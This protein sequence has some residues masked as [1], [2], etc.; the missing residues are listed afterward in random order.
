MGIRF[1]QTNSPRT[2]SPFPS[3]TMAPPSN[4]S[5][6]EP[7][8]GSADSNRGRS[9]R[10]HGGSSGSRR[11]GE[12]SRRTPA[13]GRRRNDVNGGAVD[14]IDSHVKGEMYDSA[15][16]YAK[17]PPEQAVRVPSDA[18]YPE[19]QYCYPSAQ[20]PA[21]EPTMYDNELRLDEEQPQAGTAQTHQ[22]TSY[23]SG[24]H[25]SQQMQSQY[26]YPQIPAQAS[27]RPRTPVHN[28]YQNAP[29]SPTTQRWSAEYCA[30]ERLRLG[31]PRFATEAEVE[32]A[33]RAYEHATHQADHFGAPQ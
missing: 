26:Q 7:H 33:R 18:Y 6:L 25:Y 17:S 29:T 13:P 11:A 23:S 28:N 9:P 10:P 20:F 3:D 4:S 8:N 14:Y 19:S 12:R 2:T 5:S 31:L 1:F 32:A 22:F 15:F 30:E 21:N 24:D 27:D 16:T